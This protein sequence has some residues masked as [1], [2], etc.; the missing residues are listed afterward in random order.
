MSEKNKS[1]SLGKSGL[2]LGVNGIAFCGVVFAQDGVSDLDTRFMDMEKRV[3]QLE[4]Q[5]SNALTAGSSPGSFKL[6]GSETSLTIGGFISA[7]AMLSD[8]NSLLSHAGDQLLAPQLIALDNDT[9]ETSDSQKLEMSARESRLFVRTQT[10][11][12]S[13]VFTTYV[14]GDFWGAEGTEGT[15]NGYGFRLRQAWAQLGNLTLGQGWT[16]MFNPYSMPE[17][18]DF[19]PPVGFLGG[20]RQAALKWQQPFTGGN[21]SMSL[22]NPET[23]VASAIS[24]PTGSSVTANTYHDVDEWPDLTAKISFKKGT[25][26]YAVTGLARKL[27]AYSADLT[28]GG[29]DAYGVGGMVSGG[30][31][32]GDKDR[33][34]F[35]LGYGDG[36]G[37]YWGAAV[38]DAVIVDGQLET[39]E[40]AGG[41]I[42]F[43]HYWSPTLRSSIDYSTLKMT[44]PD[45]ASELLDEKY[46]ASHVNLIW[47]VAPKAQLG[48]EYLWANRDT[49]A[50]ESGSLNRIVL[51]GKYLF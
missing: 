30:I 47:A 1:I 45:G 11:L 43:K 16:N 4:S 3:E 6:P 20:T 40:V 36:V 24:L 14:E 29:D 41:H 51:N 50:G 42:G 10:P 13:G 19:A 5:Q 15:T 26:D 44:H 12:E 37:R 22:E 28:G 25:G 35:S 23:A 17:V 38:P 48:I 8:K 7:G 33:L 21:W 34:V 32:F 39:I 46:Q 31:G 18:L 2:L 49:V 9:A 27:N